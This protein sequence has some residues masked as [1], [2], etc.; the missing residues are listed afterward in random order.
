VRK[1]SED[2]RGGE[3]RTNIGVRKTGGKAP[4]TA[5]KKAR[6][7]VEGGDD[8]AEAFCLEDVT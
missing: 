1:E 5:G 8:V 6:Q 2:P 4:I 7:C 3:E